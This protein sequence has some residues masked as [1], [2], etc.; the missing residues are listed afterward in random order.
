MN[1]DEGRYLRHN[2]IDWFSQEKLHNTCIAVIG[3]GAI[4]NEVVKN[5]TLLGVGRIDVFDFDSIEEH[6]LTKSVLFRESDIGKGKAACI[7]ERASELDPNVKICSFHGDFWDNVSV[8]EIEK[9]QSV[10]CCVDNFEARLRLN[11]LCLIA[12]VDFIN[13]GIDSRYVIVEIFPFSQGTQVPCY[14]CGLPPS[15]YQQISK[16]YSC[17]WLKRKA[18]AEKAIP[19]TIIT[20]SFAGAY[21]VSAAL[22]FGTTERGENEQIRVFFDT[23]SFRTTIIKLSKKEDCIGCSSYSHRPLIIKANNLVETI[24]DKNLQGV[25]FTSS[26]QII[27]DYYCKHGCEIDSNKYK[28][29]QARLFDD[30]IFICSHCGLSSIN[31]EIRDQFTGSQISEQFSGFSFPAK[32]L[33]TSVSDQKICFDLEESKNE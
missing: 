2:L 14:E 18:F 21:A 20:S 10:I 13:T 25:A 19:T 1:I 23:K 5:L 3:A 24:N 29:K 6:N 32:Y 9:Y 17:G 30:S 22:K 16:R 28:F 11:Q 12:G 4:G 31:V 15:V 7:A 33:L 27:T 26:D 8:S